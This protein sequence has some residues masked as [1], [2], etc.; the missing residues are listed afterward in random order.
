[1]SKYI[2]YSSTENVLNRSWVILRLSH[3]K[4]RPAGSSATARCP[5]SIIFEYLSSMRRCAMHNSTGSS[6]VA[7]DFPFPSGG[8][9]E[10]LVFA[11]GKKMKMAGVFKFDYE[12]GKHVGR[13]RCKRE[14]GSHHHLH[15]YLLMQ[16][17]IR[18]WLSEEKGTSWAQ[19]KSSDE[20]SDAKVSRLSGS[21]QFLMKKLGKYEQ[22]EERERGRANYT[23]R[24]GRNT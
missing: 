17:L 16:M 22:A 14:W 20:N 9:R 10:I 24:I 23:N 3:S 11:P 6:S 2:L 1:M 7:E 21:S 13:R 8:K 12:E 5:A 4:Y 19:I 18:L 15:P